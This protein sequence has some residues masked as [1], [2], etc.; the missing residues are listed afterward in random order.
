MIIPE[1]LSPFKDM[2]IPLGFKEGLKDVDQFVK[3]KVLTGFDG[4]KFLKEGKPIVD[5]IFNGFGVEVD[6]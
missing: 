1:K 6:V 5:N 3:V 4:E 2:V